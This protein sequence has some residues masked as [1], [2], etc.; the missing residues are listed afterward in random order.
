[1]ATD[2]GPNPQTGPRIEPRAQTPSWIRGAGFLAVAALLISAANYLFSLSMTR[3]LGSRSFVDF[4]G[5]QSLLLVIGTAVMSAVPWVMAHDIARARAHPH[6]PGPSPQQ[7]LAFGLVASGVQG[8]ILGG[9]SFVVGL[10]LGGFELGLVAGLSAFVLSMV[11]APIGFLQGENRFGSIAA[12]RLVEAVIRVGLGLVLVLLLSRTASVALVSMP[13]ASVALVGAG[14]LLCRG[15]FPL[16]RIDAEALRLLVR[17]SVSLGLVQVLL[18]CLAAIDTVVAAAVS[19]G[20]DAYPYQFAALLGRV[21][22]FVSLALGQAVFPSLSRAA[23][24]REVAREMRKALGIYARIAALTLVAFWTVPETL[25]AVAAENSA[26]RAQTLLRVTAVTG[27]TIGLLNIITTAHQ[28]RQ[29]TRRLLWTL[30]PFV[31]LQPIAIVLT[32]QPRA[33][34]D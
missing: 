25:L 17:R 5:V 12:L 11:A 23:G 29:Q 7:S 24:D 20:G 4:V 10:R 13:V 31:V 19:L 18:T 27:L 34:S 33:N 14:L 15:G 1:M 22:L 6:E 28:A 16:E 30:A 3:L 9:V 8:A 26:D 2:L 32:A 21:P